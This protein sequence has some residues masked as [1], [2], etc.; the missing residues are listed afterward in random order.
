MKV[1]FLSQRVDV[2][3]SH[4]E[5]RDCLDQ[6]W[7]NMLCGKDRVILPVPNNML[8]LSNMLKAIKPD[9]IVL[10]GGNTP[11]AYDGT[12]KER[13]CTDD[14]LINYA[15][16][17]DIPLLGVCR[18]MQSIVL[19]FGGTLEKVEKHVSVEHVI[20]DKNC[21]ELGSVNSYHNYS[22]E[23]IPYE[24]EAAA[25]SKDGKVEAV[26]HKNAR[27]YGVMWHPEREASENGKDIINRLFD[28]NL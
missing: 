13:D 20:E 6:M 25:W 26:K 9:F 11:E 10:T 19:H 12:A 28:L 8:N 15:L 1:F 24:L 14:T 18:G 4:G 21:K 2:I 27:I 16:N 3:E 23:D 22:V 7:A 17:Y 5:R